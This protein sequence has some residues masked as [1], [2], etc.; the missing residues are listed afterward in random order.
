MARATKAVKRKATAPRAIRRSAN[1][2]IIAEE[3]YI[4]RETVDFSNLS[5]EEFASKVTETL[6]HYGY[7]YDTKEGNKWA[8]AWVKKTYSKDDYAAFR[9]AEAWRTSMTVC[10]LC[11]MIENG[12]VF[13]EERIAWIRKHIDSAIKAG[14]AKKAETP[15]EDGVVVRKKSPAEILKEKTSEYLGEIEGIIDTFGTDEFDKEYSL[16]TD[17]RK[18]DIAYNTAKAIVDAYTPLVDEF[19]EL[20]GPKK[21]NDDMYDQLVEGYS[22]MTKKSQKEFLKFIQS[23]VD[24]ATSYMATKK[25]KR[26]TRAP[27]VKSAAQQVSGLKYSKESAEY[28]IASVDPQTIIGASILYLLNTKTRTL[29]RI[30]S[31]ATVGLGV[32]GTT[33]I[34]FDEDKCLKKKLRKPEDFLSAVS[35]TTKTKM[36]K[37]WNALTTKP[38]EANGRVNADTIIL[39]VF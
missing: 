29:T 24:D 27:K 7:F 1:A 17:L 11:K 34:N 38:A 2:N 32:K 36:N 18:N 19:K 28:K 16:F 33:I 5:T 3:K 22:H 8:S 12:A 37:E 9:A 6:R 30:E 31:T 25:A 4:G 15:D 20:T 13:G 14:Y 35:K 23:L 10:S 21:K 26:K 39:K